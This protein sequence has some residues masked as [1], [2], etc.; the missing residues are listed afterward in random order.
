MHTHVLVLAGILLVPIH[1]AST[2][3]KYLFWPIG[4]YPAMTSRSRVACQ[5]GDPI[6]LQYNHSRMNDTWHIKKYNAQGNTKNLLTF[7]IYW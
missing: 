3:S 6:T 7:H 2:Y 5:A 1:R 4:L